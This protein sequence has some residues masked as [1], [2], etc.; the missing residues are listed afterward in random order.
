MENEII[1]KEEKKLNFW[2]KFS[3]VEKS[4]WITISIL[5]IVVLSLSQIGQNKL[6]K[7][8]VKESIISLKE[9]EKNLFK[10]ENLLND[11]L[12]VHLGKVKNNINREIDTAFDYAFRNIDSYLDW[13]YSVVGE[14][15]QLGTLATGELTITIQEKLLGGEFNKKLQL[16]NHNISVGYKES[17]HKYYETF[18]GVALL[19][20]SQTQNKDILNALDLDMQNF[21]KLQTGKTLLVG[22]GMSG[23]LLTKMAA[24]LAS[25]TVLKVIAKAGVKTATKVGATSA[26][27]LAGLSCGALAPA[28]GAGL[29]LVTWFSV[30]AV[31][32]SLDEYMHRDELKVELVNQLKIQSTKLRNK[33]KRMYSQNFKEISE[34]LK[35][36]YSTI[37]TKKTVRESIW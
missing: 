37:E 16:A 34:K 24:R 10:K 8:G 11:E 9:I 2:Q 20:V 3:T 13:H 35:K 12:E 26:A 30:D 14:Y 19:D 32:V 21:M 6:K 4:F 29:A 33:Y 17:V 15:I 22:A 23:A 25:K 36:E 28:C 31:F 5:I 7:L 1:P 27:A 18:K